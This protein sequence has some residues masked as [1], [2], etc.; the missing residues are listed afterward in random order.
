MAD[1]TL[2]SKVSE[3]TARIELLLAKV[4]DLTKIVQR[5]S[6]IETF[7]T[8]I[9]TR[10]EFAEVC[11]VSEATIRRREGRGL[12]NPPSEGEQIAIFNQGNQ[13]N[14]LVNIPLAMNY[15]ERNLSKNA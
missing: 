13:G 15:Y 2:Q 4:E 6:D 7:K 3:A 1:F 8:V 9:G 14:I 12:Y 11:R 10:K 5:N